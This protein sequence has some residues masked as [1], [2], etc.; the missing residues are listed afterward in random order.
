MEPEGK[1]HFF[2]PCAKAVPDKDAKPIQPGCP[3]SPLL[4]QIPRK[5]SLKPNKQISSDGDMVTL[6]GISGSIY[7]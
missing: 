7:E 3:A 6:T 4:N 2:F 5:Q 1:Y